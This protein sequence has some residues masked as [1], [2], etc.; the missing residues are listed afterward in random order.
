[1]QFELFQK[2]STPESV[3]SF[4]LRLL[5][6]VGLNETGFW[7]RVRVGCIG[8]FYVTFLVIP[9]LTGGY[10]DV[11]QRVR[12]GV[13][14]L[15]NCNIYGGCFV[16][17]YNIATFQTFIQ[18]LRT[19]SVVVCSHSY[20]LKQTLTRCNRRA[21][22]I[23][24]VQTACM[25]AVTFFYWIAPIPSIY[26]SH[27]IS[28]SINST[29]PVRLVQHLEVKFYW[30]D[31][32]NCVKDYLIFTIIMLPVII[33]CGFVCNL[34]LLSICSCIEH[35]TLLTRLTTKA[36]EQMESGKL[37]ERN[38]TIAI[39]NVVEMHT[40]LLNC[41]RLLNTSLQSML[42]L[43]WLVC[44]LNWSIS[45][46]YL[47]NVGICLK[48]V[49][50]VVMFFLITAETF[51]YCFLGSRLATQQLLLER[52]IYA[53]RWYNYPTVL[54]RSVRM[55]LRQSQ[56]HEHITV[57]KFFRVNLE[58]F[59]R[60]VNLSYSAYVVLKDEIKMDLN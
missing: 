48:S 2:Y 9:P 56:R 17:A 28:E 53:I 54:Q 12:A 50:V 19:F 44:G 14:F 4:V 26:Y 8:L 6:I 58:E 36:V 23:A 27:H 5:H 7:S 38:I 39:S 32:R 35:C 29:A 21:D 51:L 31:N 55:M 47:T 60:I 46:L 16:F 15:F 33:M 13:E 24:K 49:T 22:F 11:H 20:T 43:Q 59:S 3:L 40:R 10:T 25:A 34:K 41:I 42:L 52:A 45:Y 30:L 1:M 37:A 18:E 57:G